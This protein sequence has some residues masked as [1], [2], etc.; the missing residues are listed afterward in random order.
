MTRKR[1]VG[2]LFLGLVFFVCGA[3]GARM[4]YKFPMGYFEATFWFDVLIFAAIAVIGLTI[5]TYAAFWLGRSITRQS[6]SETRS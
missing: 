6:Q 3:F 1:A 4:F 2:T 5:A